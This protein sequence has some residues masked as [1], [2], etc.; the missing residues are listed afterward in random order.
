[1]SRPGTSGDNAPI[2][3]FWSHLK[4]EDLSFKTALTKEELLRNITE[5]ID[6]Y[7]NGRR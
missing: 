7:N 4:E 1:M 5:A 2:K 6:W 3:S